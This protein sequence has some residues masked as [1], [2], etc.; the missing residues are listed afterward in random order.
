MYMYVCC[1]CLGIHCALLLGSSALQQLKIQKATV[2]TKVTELV[3]LK[4][5][6][7]ALPM[8]HDTAAHGVGHSRNGLRC[9]AFSGAQN[10]LLWSSAA[11]ASTLHNYAHLD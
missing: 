6:G 3:T 4:A 2:R 10:A 5:D 11:T 7:I 1:T 9:L 8:T